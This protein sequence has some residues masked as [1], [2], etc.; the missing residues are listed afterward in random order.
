MPAPS[1]YPNLK[2]AGQGRPQKGKRKRLSIQ[3]APNV[4]AYLESK[5]GPRGIGKVIEEMVMTQVAETQTKT[6]SAGRLNISGFARI[7]DIIELDGCQSEIVDWEGD[8]LVLR[9]L[10][11]EETVKPEFVTCQRFSGCP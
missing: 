1:E 11:D 9:S 6:V 3:V 5:G 2:N 7:G 10:S 4:A 8:D